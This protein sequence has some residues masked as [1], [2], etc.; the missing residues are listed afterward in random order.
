MTNSMVV[1]YKLMDAS[2]AV[3]EQWG[4]IWGQCPD[5]PNPLLLPNGVQIC[6]VTEVGPLQDGYSI[7]GWWM[8]EPVIAPQSITP[9]QCR[10]MLSQQGLLSQVEEMIASSTEDVRI[11]W[12]YALEFRRNDPTLNQFA[13]NLTPPLT[14]EQIDQFFISASKL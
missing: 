5:I 2:G 4:G 11:T 12:E 6:G 14:S 8:D 1:G 3:V 7:M 13:A 9:R 10:L